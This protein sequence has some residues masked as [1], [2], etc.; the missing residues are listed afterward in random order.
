ML[1]VSYPENYPNYTKLVW[2]QQMQVF[3]SMQI[4]LKEIMCSVNVNPSLSIGKKQFL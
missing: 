3:L 4:V 1:Y 2:R